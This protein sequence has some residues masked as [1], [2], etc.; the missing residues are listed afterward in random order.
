MSGKPPSKD[1][2]VATREA[3]DA[4]QPDR[5]FVKLDSGDEYG[6]VTKAELDSWVTEER[7]DEECQ[8]LRKGWDQWKWASD[9]YPEL[10]NGSSPASESAEPESNFQFG[11][12]DRGPAGAS[13]PFTFDD[14]Y[15]APRGGGS[16]GGSGSS[17]GAIPETAV[18]LFFASK[19][20]MIVTAVAFTLGAIGQ[21]LSFFNILKTLGEAP[22]ELRAAL[23]VAL[24]ISLPTAAAMIWVVVSLYGYIGGVNRLIRERSGASLTYLAQRH[25]AFWFA[26]GLIMLVG[27]ILMAI[28]I[29]IL[30]TLILAALSMGPAGLGR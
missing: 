1:Q 5:W 7:L 13:S 16:G 27:L 28:G 17:D 2:A 20:W 6:P 4:G 25:N 10:E 26:L 24:V 14:A 23:M 12:N 30:I 29:F 19:M 8:V 11:G 18:R 22:P 15:R 9:V 3:A 21:T